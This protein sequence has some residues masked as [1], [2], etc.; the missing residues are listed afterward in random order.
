VNGGGLKS[1][2]SEFEEVVPKALAKDPKRHFAS[3]S[4][5]TAA[6]EQASFAD[7]SDA[8]THTNPHVSVANGY[9]PDQVSP[10]ASDKS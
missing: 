8:L 5:F 2:E 9:H 10:A 6:L 3:M 7:D 1:R 4:D